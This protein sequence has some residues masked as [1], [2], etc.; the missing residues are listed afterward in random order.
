ME[1]QRDRSTQH[2][3]HI[4]EEGNTQ[5]SREARCNSHSSS[6]SDALRTCAETRI[7]ACS[8]KQKFKKTKQLGLNTVTVGV[9][10]SH[11]AD[12]VQTSSSL[13]HE[14]QPSSRD[15][16]DSSLLRSRGKFSSTFVA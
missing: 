9:R 14:R 12:L 11:V 3:H 10:V 2:Q 1:S 6:F 4:R 7:L 5:Q 13:L 15:N 16:N 8:Q